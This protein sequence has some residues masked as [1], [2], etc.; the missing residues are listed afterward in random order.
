MQEC[1][2]WGKTAYDFGVQETLKKLPANNTIHVVLETARKL[3]DLAVAHT[4]SL[5]VC[6]L[7]SVT[8]H[9]SFNN[10][11]SWLSVGCSCR[12]NDGCEKPSSSE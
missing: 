4:Q 11:I 9:F 3:R 12:R 8:F 2:K 1:V 7:F 6:V 10:L 5:N